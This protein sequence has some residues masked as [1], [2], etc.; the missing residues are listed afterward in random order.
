MSRLLVGIIFDESCRS[1]RNEDKRGCSQ[2]NLVSYLDV[3]IDNPNGRQPEGNTGTEDGVP[4]TQGVPE[5]LQHKEYPS[6][7]NVPVLGDFGLL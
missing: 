6:T 1:H 7:C 3:E 5:Y 4:A 2:S